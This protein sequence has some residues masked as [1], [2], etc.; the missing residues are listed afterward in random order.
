[1]ATHCL[2]THLSLAVTYPLPNCVLHTP[3]LKYA[4]RIVKP[5]LMTN[6]FAQAVLQTWTTFALS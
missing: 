2:G 5:L 1:M 4:N 6:S 3:A